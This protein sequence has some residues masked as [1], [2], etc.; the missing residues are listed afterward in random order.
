MLMSHLPERPHFVQVHSPPVRV[1]SWFFSRKGRYVGSGVQNGAHWCCLVRLPLSAW[2]L[3]PHF[4]QAS[5]FPKFW[6]W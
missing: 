1:R 3:R 6:M 5:Y 2:V 4:K